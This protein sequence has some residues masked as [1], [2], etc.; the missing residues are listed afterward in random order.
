[1][2]LDAHQMAVAA[3][4]AITSDHPHHQPTRL[5]ASV[6][7]PAADPCQSGAGDGRSND[8]DPEGSLPSQPELSAPF[9]AIGDTGSHSGHG[10]APRSPKRSQPVSTVSRVAFTSVL[11]MCQLARLGSPP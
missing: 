7:F 6:R 10:W 5:E 1:M 9:T 3:G 11:L 2:N 8:V 4:G